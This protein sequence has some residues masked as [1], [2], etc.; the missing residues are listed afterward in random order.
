VTDGLTVSVVVPAHDAAEHIAE[1]LAA[2]RSQDAPW[3]E[4]VIVVDNASADDTRA[5][6]EGVAA[7]WSKVT[8]VDEPRPGGNIARNA[9][10]RATTTDGVLLCDADDVVADGWIAA[11]RAA[12]VGQDLVRGRYDLARLNDPDTIAARGPVAATSGP[13]P[14]RPVNGLGGN[15]GFRKA[16][17]EQLGGLAEHHYG[18]DEEELFWRAHL[19]GLR[20]GYVED[21]VVHYRLRPS[22]R[23]LY[24]QQRAWASNRAQLYREF[25]RY[26]F[27]SRRSWPA[28]VKGWGWLAVHLPDA[29]SDDPTRRGCWVRAAAHNVG[30]VR[31]SVRHRVVYP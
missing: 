4:E 2:L 31:G 7:E 29:W 11:L 9:G 17:W 18:S 26:G 15:C 30:A 12:L 5:V 19:A 28:A 14:G 1:Q 23:D 8:V 21:A 24:R 27:I 20:V 13:A 16:A 10:A 3:L 25:G 6:V 22:Y